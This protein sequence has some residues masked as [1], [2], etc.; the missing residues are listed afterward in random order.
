MLLPTAA[1]DEDVIKVGNSEALT[2]AQH[3]IDQPLEGGSS[4]MQAL[5]HK[6]KLKESFRGS[7]SCFEAVFG[8]QWDLPVTFG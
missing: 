3:Y 1:V 4:P 6:L 7:E 5:G 2:F 8:L